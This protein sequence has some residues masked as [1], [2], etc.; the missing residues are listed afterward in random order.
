MNS[1]APAPSVT[2]QAVALIRADLERPHTPLGDP[3][4]QRALCLG[5]NFTPPGWLR[6]GIEA[7]TSFMD[8]HVLAATARGVRQ[9][10]ICGAGLDDRALRLRAPGVRFTEIDHPSTQADKARR[11]A[12]MAASADGLTLAPCDFR[13]GSVAETLA[14]CGHDPGQETLFLCEGLLIYLDEQACARLLEGMASC[15]AAG[16]MLAVTLATHADGLDSADVVAAAN[17]RRR[18]GVSE[19]WRT[20]LPAAEHLAML[21]RSGWTVTSVA[22]SPLAHPEVSH[23]RR[24][25]LVTAVAARPGT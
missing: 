23:G 21:E 14:G 3:D 9:V 10:V 19:P 24:S 4:A 25:L 12:A 7:R 20:I 2:S 11:L 22:E 5:L 18:A 17:A 8:E 6:A 16:S 1:P 13:T 15:A